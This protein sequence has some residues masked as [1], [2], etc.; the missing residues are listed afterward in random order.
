MS[1]PTIYIS[2]AITWVPMS[3]L[4]AICICLRVI[5]PPLEPECSFQDTD[6]IWPSSILK[7][8]SGT[9]CSLSKDS[10]PCGP[11]YPL[12][13]LPP[14]PPSSLPVSPSSCFP[15][16]LLHRTPASALYHLFT[17]NPSPTSSEEKK[18]TTPPL[19]SV[20]LLEQTR[21][22]ISLHHSDYFIVTCEIIGSISFCSSSHVWAPWEQG[23]HFFVIH[24]HT[25]SI[26]TS[27]LI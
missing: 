15:R 26:N 9:H 21:A 11:W 4:S 16:H 13:P 25:P 27:L 19:Q 22:L 17:C 20:A 7:P 2:S 23:Y 14:C 6:A 12:W 10:L 1:L 18:K 5:H 24:H 3:Y 8:F